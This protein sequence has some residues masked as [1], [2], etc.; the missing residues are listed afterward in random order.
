MAEPTVPV[1]AVRPPVDKPMRLVGV[2]H[3]NNSYSL[4][5][6]ASSAN[7]FHHVLDIVRQNLMGILHDQLYYMTPKLRNELE[8]L[9]QDVEALAKDRAYEETQDNYR[10]PFWRADYEAEN[11]Y[12]VTKLSELAHALVDFKQNCCS[13]SRS[14]EALNEDMLQRLCQKH[15]DEVVNMR[16]I[17][18]PSITSAVYRNTTV[19]RLSAPLQTALQWNQGTSPLDDP[20]V[21]RQLPQE[22]TLTTHQS[23]GPRTNPPLVNGKVSGVHIIPSQWDVPDLSGKPGAANSGSEGTL[24]SRGRYGGRQ[25]YEQSVNERRRPFQEEVR[26]V[27][28]RYKHIHGLCE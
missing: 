25:L 20:N 4:V 3:S 10:H 7:E 22:C 21:K 18:A 12:L 16:R 26:H 2:S 5:G 24:T 1:P 6:H 13:A 15:W 11:K 27:S 8:L 23:I 9:V 19:T 14:T 17:L 28:S